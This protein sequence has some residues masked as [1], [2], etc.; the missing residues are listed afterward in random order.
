MRGIAEYSARVLLEL[1]DQRKVKPKCS[2]TCL[3]RHFLVRYTEGKK[4]KTEWLS[5]ATMANW[6]REES[7]AMVKQWN[8][9]LAA[10]GKGDDGELLDP[11][12]QVG[13]EN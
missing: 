11:S 7:K 12:I 1:L 13:D 9:D 4:T 6:W 5:R 8:D 10:A 3:Q 2:S